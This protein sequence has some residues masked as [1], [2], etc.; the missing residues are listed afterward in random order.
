MV[1]PLWDG[2]E[3]GVIKEKGEFINSVSADILLRRPATPA[4]LAGI[5]AFLAS[6]D[7]DYMPGQII[8]CDGGMVLV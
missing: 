8:M 6:S 4:D 1:T 7:S 3:R 2:L 5:C